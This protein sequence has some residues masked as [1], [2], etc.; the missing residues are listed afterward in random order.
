MTEVD[1]LSIFK[2]QYE[3][4]GDP[5]NSTSFVE[6]VNLVTYNISAFGFNGTNYNLT[7]GGSSNV[8]L[9][10][11]NA[12]KIYSS[13]NGGVQYNTTL[14][15]GAGNRLDDEYYKISY[16]S[17]S[18]AALFQTPYDVNFTFDNTY[19]MNTFSLDTSSSQKDVIGTTKPLLELDNSVRINGSM[20]IESPLFA[21]GTVTVSGNL[22]ADSNFRCSKSIFGSNINV[23]RQR[24]EGDID[25]IGYGFQVNT[26]NQLELIKTTVFMNSNVVSKKVAIFGWNEFGSDDPSDASYLV[27]DELKGLGVSS[28]GSGSAPVFT[29]GGYLSLDGGSM[30]GSIDMNWNSLSNVSYMSASNVSSVVFEALGSDYA[31]YVIKSNPDESFMKGQVVGLDNQGKVTSVFDDSIR[32]MIVSDNPG[33]IGGKQPSGTSCEI[34][35]F[36]GR[37]HAQKPVNQCSQGDYLVPVKGDDGEINVVS[38]S[39]DGMSF[40]DYVKSIGQVINIDNE[41]PLVIVK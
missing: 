29:S 10:G 2:G 6:F 41:I 19:T 12:V 4:I 26:S 27:F 17:A 21:Y 39:K 32:F 9:E 16:D 18:N 30:N 14:I 7:L 5:V 3:T 22:M 40:Q 31:E 20:S 1:N 34:I 11:S 33:V 36:C 35:A 15:D 23:Y 28:G 37:V 24:G 25:T 8:V 13:S 38:M